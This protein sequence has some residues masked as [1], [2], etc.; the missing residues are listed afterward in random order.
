MCKRMVSLP[1][2]YHSLCMLMPKSN[3]VT[4]H[5]NHFHRLRNCADKFLY[6][7]YPH[8]FV[9]VLRMHCLLHIWNENKGIRRRYLYRQWQSLIERSKCCVLRWQL[10]SVLRVHSSYSALPVMCWCV[11]CSL[12]VVHVFVCVC[13]CVVCANEYIIYRKLAHSQAAR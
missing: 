8:I 9:I 12:F 13:V 6:D 1:H 5:R 7:I 3:H 11:C 4:L 2:I 10:D